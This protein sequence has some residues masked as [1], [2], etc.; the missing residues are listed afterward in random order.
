MKKSANDCQEIDT[1]NS[2]R[3]HQ[4]VHEKRSLNSR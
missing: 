4:T 1:E 2:K 3:E